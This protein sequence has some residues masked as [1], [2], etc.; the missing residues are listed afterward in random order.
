M[1][2]EAENGQFKAD[3]SRTCVALKYLE[4]SNKSPENSPKNKTF[5]HSKRPRFSAN[6]LAT[7]D[8]C[9]VPFIDF[10]LRAA[11]GI[12]LPSRSSIQHQPTR[13]LQTWLVYLYAPQMLLFIIT[14]LTGE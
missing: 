5:P 6:A 8:S 2:V 13:C 7:G 3:V 9:A 4:I 10:V 1:K 14:F 12:H 11:F